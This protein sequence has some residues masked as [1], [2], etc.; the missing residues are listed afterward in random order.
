MIP[1]SAIFPVLNLLVAVMADRANAIR[2]SILKTG[3]GSILLSIRLT[4]K[5]DASE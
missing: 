5:M 2:I 1:A 3:F 4:M